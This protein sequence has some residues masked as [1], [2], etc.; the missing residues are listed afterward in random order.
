MARHHS[1]VSVPGWP[2]AF[3]GSLAVAAGLVTW[4][5]LRGPRYLRLFPDVCVPVGAEPPDLALRSRAAYRLVEG[6]GV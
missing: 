4:D 6:R 2:T 1:G 5:R 3:R